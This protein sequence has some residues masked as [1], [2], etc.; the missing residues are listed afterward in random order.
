MVAQQRLPGT[1]ADVPPAAGATALTPADA[2]GVQAAAV[3]AATSGAAAAADPAP[4]AGPVAA[5]PEQVGPS[6]AGLPRWLVL[7]VGCAAATIAIAGVR[8]I[9][10]LVGPVLLALVVVIALMPVQ[11]F[12]QRHGWPRWLSAAVLL[13]L[14]W[15]ILLA[16]VALLV[17]SIAQFANLL[18]DYAGSAERLLASVV[19][20]LNDR[21]IVSGQL[22]DL[23]AQFDYSQLVGVATGL[24]ARVSDAATTLV[25]LLSAIVF[26]SIESGGFGRRLALVAAE[27]PHLPIALGL[28]ARGTRSYLLVSTVFGAI[29]AI[30][31]TIAL[32]IIGIPLPVVWG[33]LSFITNYVPNIGFVLGLV[34]PAIL[35]LLGGGWTEFWVVVA[36]YAL[37]NFVVQTLIQPRFVGDSVGL[38]MTVTFVAL[39]FWGWVLGALGALLAIPL[40]L[41]VKAMLV[42]VDPRGHWLDALLRE[43]PRAPR[44]SRARQRANAR[45][46][47]LASV[48]ALQPHL[49]GR[50]HSED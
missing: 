5:A 27:R 29:V 49:P 3:D 47:A 21:G 12:L 37:L 48:R 24:L 6:T 19:A 30:G 1:G 17:V 36:V 43:E 45:R 32:A 2:A 50:K 31:D 13:V 28:F 16:F 10:W 42:D 11:R 20:D 15:S 40:T 8:S 7:L 4:A 38:S 41:L 35:G 33:L 23:V 34:P 39:L 9:A 25:L 26:L 46:A 22:S 44:T 14:V 18:P